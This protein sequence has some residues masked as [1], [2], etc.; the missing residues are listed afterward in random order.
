MVISTDILIQLIGPILGAAS[1]VYA[2]YLGIKQKRI[3]NAKAE[4][5]RLRKIED[6]KDDLHDESIADQVKGF[7]KTL[8]DMLKLKQTEN[9]AFQRQILELNTQIAK[10]TEKFNAVKS[11]VMTMDMMG[12]NSPIAFWVKDREGNRI[13][14]NKA[15][16]DMTGFYFTKCF[17][18]NDFE[19]TK[20]KILADNWKVVDHQVIKTGLPVM[21]KELCGH[22]DNPGVYFEVF[23]IKWPKVIKTRDGEHVIGVEGAAIKVEQ[24]EDVLFKIP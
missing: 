14:H 10:L 5:D 18:K 4:S 9:E 7:H 19:I 13:Y 2:T 3:E 17:G 11:G 6:E 20:D 16:E 24:M 21:A 23:T 22:I 12:D 15:Y 1:L 8:L